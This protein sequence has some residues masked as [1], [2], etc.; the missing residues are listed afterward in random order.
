MFAKRQS[1]IALQTAVAGP[2]YDITH[3]GR[4]TYI[5]TSAIL[6]EKTL[7]V[8]ISNR[9]MD[10]EAEVC[11]S[12]EDNAISK[13]ENAELLTGGGDPKAA[14]SF[15]NPDVVGTKS[16]TDVQFTNGKARFILPP[17]SVSG[18]EPKND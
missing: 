18:D 10:E 5:D 14:N 6:D 7:H 9:S 3:N 15:E 8:F 12:L 17:L 1:G 11:I 2:G 13:L 16:F 4:V